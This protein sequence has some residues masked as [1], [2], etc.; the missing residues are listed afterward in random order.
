MVEQ[1]GDVIAERALQ[2]LNF[3][4]LA[5]ERAA[6]HQEHSLGSAPIRLRRHRL[7]RRPAE[8]HRFHCAKRDAPRLQ[9][10][11]P[12]IANAQELPRR[13]L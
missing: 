4:G 11:P 1:P 9:H 7:R 12:P 8:C 3:A 2:F 13:I 5:V 10:S 6:D